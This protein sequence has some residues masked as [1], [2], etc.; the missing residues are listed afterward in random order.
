ME[1]ARLDAA[2]L[3]NKTYMG[4]PCKFHRKSPRYVLTGRCQ[5][6]DIA[7]AAKRYAAVKTMLEGVRAEYVNAE[8]Q[9]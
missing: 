4:K 2:R 8:Q 9:G 6:C 1:Q 3:G 5:A 7:K